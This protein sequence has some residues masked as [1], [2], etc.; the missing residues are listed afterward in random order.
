MYLAILGRQP[1]ISIAELESVVGSDCVKSPSNGV[2]EL[3]KLPDIARLGGTLKLAEIVAQGSNISNVDKVIAEILAQKDGKITF[4]ISGYGVNLPNRLGLIIKKILKSKDRSVRYVQAKQGSCLNTAE[5]FHNKLDKSQ[6]EIIVTKIDGKVLIARTVAVQNIQS[7]TKRDQER[8][9]RDS[10]VGMLP[11]KLAQTIINIS[12]PTNQDGYVLDPFCGTGVVLQEA[13]LMGFRAHGSDISKRMIKYS[14]E[15]MKWLEGSLSTNFDYS[16]EVGDA[17]NHQWPESINSVAC[18]AFLGTAFTHTPRDH[19]L[20]SAIKEA[21]QII[22]EFL[23]NISSQIKSGTKL[24]VGVPQWQVRNKIHSLPVVDKLD[25][26]GYTWSEFSHCDSKK[27]IYRRPGQVV[28]RH[29][30]PLA[31]K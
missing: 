18:E 14:I 27:L 30:L 22:E 25:Q 24:C 31:K 13:V 28:G 26:L 6:S 4:G 17:K 19:E 16:A 23:K 7:Y 5:V 1:E 12:Q 9:A 3:T 15:N 11:P 21:D 10:K 8:P 2:V 29:L 20:N